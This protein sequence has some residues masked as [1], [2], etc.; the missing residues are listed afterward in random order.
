MVMVLDTTASRKA[1]RPD[2]ATLRKPDW[3]RIKAPGSNAYAEVRRVVRDHDLHTVCVA[4]PKACCAHLAG[5]LQVSDKC[6]LF[7]AA[8]NLCR[9]SEG[10]LT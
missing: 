6:G 10:P 3:I 8:F 4:T 9:C 2:T 1:R 7:S 5:P